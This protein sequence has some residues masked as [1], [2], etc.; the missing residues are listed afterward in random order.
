MSFQ[1]KL[2]AK[3]WQ[4]GWIP[5][6]L[7]RR[8]YKWSRIGGKS[9]S[10]PFETEFY[11][12]RYQGNLNNNIEFSI[13]YYGAFEKPML[14]FLR[15]AFKSLPGKHKTFCDVGA[16]IGQH[17]L[18]MSSFAQQIHAFEPYEPVRAKLQQHIALNKLE[19]ITVHPVGLSDADAELPFYAPTGSNQGIG[20]FDS[21]TVSKGNKK[22]GE[23]R[24]V[25]GSDY[26]E[27]QGIARINL[28]KID[29]EGFEKPALQ[30]LS[31]A[32]TA[33][34]PLVVCEISYKGDLAFEDMEDLSNHFPEDYEF[35]TFDNR[36][37]NGSKARRKGSKA[38]RSGEYQLVPFVFSSAAGQDD[39]V[40]C[41]KELL[42]SLPR[43]NISGLDAS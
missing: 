33:N 11:G 21:S 26:L 4:S 43:A 36:K 41:P 15:D 17:S 30:G 5:P 24:L 7:G 1:A 27:A 19:N 14:F 38:K 10:H 6:H 16:N 20:S 28:M 23:L 39:I 31:E 3:L 34:R 37:A 40:A 22:I 29:V 12:L 9:I 42:G 32:L 2:A 18:F 25:R 8:L 35:F 13:F